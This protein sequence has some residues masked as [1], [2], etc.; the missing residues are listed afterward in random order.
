MTGRLA[1]SPPAASRAASSAAAPARSA[2]CS[3]RRWRMAGLSVPSVTA[4]TSRAILR[5]SWASRCS[6]GPRLMRRA[7]SSAA[8]AR[9]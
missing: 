1:P 5:S 3:A 4:S 9:W 6:A 8:Q 7:A 2:S